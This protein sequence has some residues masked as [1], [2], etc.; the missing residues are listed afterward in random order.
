MKTLLRSAKSE[1][2]IN[3]EGAFA[4]V[5]EKINPTGNKAMA[6]A[7]AEGNLE[8]AKELAVQQIND[9][10]RVLDINA[11]SEQENEMEDLPTIA[12][13]VAETVDVP[14]C[15]DSANRH[16]LIK[17][18][19]VLPGKCLVN[20][21]SGEEE[22]MELLLPVIKDTGSAVIGLTFDNDGIPHNIDKR[23]Q[24]ADKILDRAAKYGIPPEDVVIDPLVM[25][26]GADAKAG[27]ITIGSIRAIREKFGVNIISG[28]SNI[29]FGMPNRGVLN[30][31]FMAL[32]MEA[33]MTCAITDPG[34][35]VPTI[36]SSDILLG[37]T[38]SL[39]FLNYWRRTKE[40]KEAA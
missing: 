5:G 21:V 38:D 9:G 11:D 3:I 32:A 19:E 18:L 35:M 28:A 30:K 27:L 20:S 12:M 31:A 26:V 7:M 40:N 2:E 8:F 29:S 33:G 23:L 17:T 4:V 22:V 6:A 16:A 34:S 37:R 14:L 10:A 24:I 13:M 15:L 1:V 25:T 39:E 36:L